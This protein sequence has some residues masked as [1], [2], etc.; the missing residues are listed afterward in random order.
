MMAEF[1]Y[2]WCNDIVQPIFVIIYI[3]LD[4]NEKFVL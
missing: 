3:M 4:L 2:Y 1:L